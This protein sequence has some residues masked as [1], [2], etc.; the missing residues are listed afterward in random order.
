MEIG[1]PFPTN[2]L[3]YDQGL[4]TRKPPTN[5]VKLSVIGIKGVAIY[6]N[7]KFIVKALEIPEKTKK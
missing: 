6:T 7:L 2:M 3:C 1:G 5:D 4:V